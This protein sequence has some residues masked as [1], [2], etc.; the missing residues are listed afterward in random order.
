MAWIRNTGQSV[1]W[2][3]YSL[4]LINFGYYFLEE[5]YIA[6]HTL[7]QGGSLVDWAGAFAT[8][9]DEFA[10]LSLLLLFELETWQLSDR[11]LERRSVRWSIHGLRVLCYL[12]LAH[13]VLQWTTGLL[14][15][16]RVA[17]EPGLTSL[18]QVAGKDISFGSNY[19]YRVIDSSNCD[20]LSSDDRFYFLEPSVLTDHAGYRLERK[21]MWVDLNDACVWLIIVLLIELAVRLQERGA[22]GRLLNGIDASTKLLYGVLIAHAIFWLWLGHWVYAWDQA[23]WIGGFWFIGR[24]LAEWQ[25]ETKERGR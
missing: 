20:S 11:A 8:T 1:K 18:C 10:W 21:L 15:F 17:R 22:D 3:I 7:S 25:R 24:N 6:S 9:F 23:L 4:L 12:L 13:T 2:V 16:G 14:E 19:R 5:I